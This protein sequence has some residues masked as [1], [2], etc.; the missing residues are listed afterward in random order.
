MSNSQE[1]TELLTELSE[2][3][4]APRGKELMAQI[5]LMMALF[6]RQA[7]YK[8]IVDTASHDAI[9]RLETMTKEAFAPY[10]GQEHSYKTD[11]G[12][13]FY[14]LVKSFD[15]G[16][17]EATRELIDLYADLFPFGGKPKSRCGALR[18]T[19]IMSTEHDE[20][21]FEGPDQLLCPVCGTPRTLC[22]NAPRP[23]G[24][25]AYHG[26]RSSPSTRLTK[27]ALYRENIV[28]PES[29]RAMEMLE[30]DQDAISLVPEI[31]LLSNR[32]AQ[33]LNSVEQ[34]IDTKGMVKQLENIRKKVEKAIEEG[35]DDIAHGELIKAIKVLE[36]REKADRY[37][38][39]I[40][41]TIKVLGVQADRERRRVAMEKQMIPLER[42]LRLQDETLEQVR[43]AL[44]RAASRLSGRVIYIIENQVLAMLPLPEHTRETIIN[45]LI[46]NKKSIADSVVTTY[47]H[48]IGS[49]MEER[50]RNL[51][52]SMPQTITIPEL[53]PSIIEG[54]S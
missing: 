33:L 25:C 4:H 11:L 27:G 46:D 6:D 45:G 43:M 13:Y 14:L 15:G 54:D 39:D 16:H 22:R 24:R 36:G 9:I 32:V 29:K 37:W 20:H 51:E 42:A 38:G 41:E 52:L 49:F 31:N 21:R 30:A 50:E 34:G 40:L 5:G 23:N 7:A 2:Y 35:L 17:I 26:G 28:D 47:E 53:P 3:V 44:D 19:C 8:A 12:R 18:S 10:P 1:I 48:A